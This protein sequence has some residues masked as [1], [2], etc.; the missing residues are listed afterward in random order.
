LIMFHT[1]QTS[2]NDRLRIA[3]YG[4]GLDLEQ[5]IATRLQHARDVTRAVVGHE[6][7][8]PDRRHLARLQGALK[9]SHL[10]TLLRAIAFRVLD[11]SPYLFFECSQDL[12]APLRVLLM[13]L[14]A[15]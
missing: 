12:I 6:R 10:S 14:I 2:A 3:Q 7:E 11:P 8:R 1:A 15:V 5:I 4:K 9:L 13:L